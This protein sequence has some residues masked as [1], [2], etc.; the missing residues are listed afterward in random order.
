VERQ[1]RAKPKIN[2]TSSP[3]LGEGIPKR[4]ASEQRREDLRNH[5]CDQETKKKKNRCRFLIKGAKGIYRKQDKGPDRWGEKPWGWKERPL[6]R[7][8]KKKKI[9]VFAIGL[10][11]KKNWNKRDVTEEIARGGGSWKEHPQKKKKF[12][13]KRLPGPKV[14]WN[15]PAKKREP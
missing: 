14:Q 9:K 8:E 3:A 13:D 2:R 1:S 6:Q 10:R 15:L 4:K 12:G 7:E 5:R 11:G